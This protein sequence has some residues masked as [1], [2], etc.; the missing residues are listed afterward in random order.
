MPKVHIADPISTLQFIDIDQVIEWENYSDGKLLA[1]PF[2]IEAKSISNHDNIAERIHTAAGEITQNE[3]IGVSTPIPSNDTAVKGNTPTSFLIY[4]LSNEDVD[5]LMQCGVWSSL[6]ITFQ[7]AD[8]HPPQPNFLFMIKG[9]KTGDD[10]SILQMVKATWQSNDAQ[11]IVED[12]V[13][14]FNE[15]CH[16]EIK[17][18]IQSFLT[19]V[20]I[21]RLKFKTKGGINAPHFNIYADG[22]FILDDDIW[23][24]LRES[25]AMLPYA[26]SMQ[27]LGTTEIPHTPCAICHGIDHPTGMCGFLKVVGWNGPTPKTITLATQ[28]NEGRY[29]CGGCNN[30]QIRL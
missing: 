8:L 7:V 26:A 15:D 9:F 2:G 20:S 11:N 1:I 27:G 4:N 29:G 5:T 28:Q 21:K 25:L 22:N 12:I 24:H 3:N 6:A 17:G 16:P 18:N 30:N 10:T 23:V 19:S 13:E 14:A